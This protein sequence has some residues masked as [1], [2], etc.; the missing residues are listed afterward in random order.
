MICAGSVAFCDKNGSASA[1]L[2]DNL[3]GLSPRSPCTARFS[4]QKSFRPDGSENTKNS[5]TLESQNGE[6]SIN[7]SATACKHTHCHS[8]ALAEESLRGERYF[9]CAQYDKGSEYDDEIL[10]LRETLPLAP[11]ARE[12]EINTQAQESWQADNSKDSKILEEKSPLCRF[13]QRDRTERSSRK[14]ESN[15]GDFYPKAEST[16]NHQRDNAKKE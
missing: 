12:G 10:G 9:A 5:Q 16:Q 8:E 6:T 11:S 1:R 14:R 3:R 13:E 15:L 2:C 7:L 4:H